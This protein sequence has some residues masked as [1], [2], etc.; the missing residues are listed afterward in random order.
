[1]RAPDKAGDCSGVRRPEAFSYHAVNSASGNEF[2][3]KRGAVNANRDS[4]AFHALRVF[5]VVVI[6]WP[7]G[8]RVRI[9][10]LRR[11]RC[12]DL[13]HDFT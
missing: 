2:C 9:V 12:N 3:T 7:L 11:P 8:L 4:A 1:M 10:D 6:E 13:I 5:R